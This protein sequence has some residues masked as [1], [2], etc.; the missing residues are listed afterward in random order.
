MLTEK[1][2]APNFSL[3]DQNGKEV[4]L[5]SFRGKLFVLYFYPKDMTPGCT[6]QA[7]NLRDNF[8]SL[9]DKGITILGVSPDDA[10]SHRHFITEQNI[11]FT[12]LC[13]TDKK[14]INDYGV[15]GEKSWQGKT[16][17]GVIRTT[18]L[19]DKE[20]EIQKIIDKP[21]VKNH[22]KEILEGFGLQNDISNLY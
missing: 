18:F 12:L 5:E 2:K 20:G 4:S 1:Q 8:S 10:A 17:M 19:I 3:H 6:T 11:P 22:A 15:W 13:D 21:D 14:V 9:K 7:C 16:S